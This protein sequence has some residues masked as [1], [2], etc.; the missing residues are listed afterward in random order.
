MNNVNYLKYWT[1]IS[2]YQYASFDIFDTLVK[3]NVPSPADVFRIVENKYNAKYPEN[4]IVE[5]TEKRKQAERMARK[6]KIREEINFEDIYNYIDFTMEIKSKLMRIEIQTEKSVCTPNYPIKKLYRK[7]LENKMK[8]IITSDMYLPETVIIQILQK[9]GYEDYYKLYLSSNIGF[10]KITGNLFRYILKDLKINAKQMIHIGDSK[11]ADFIS[12]FKQGIHPI[13]ISRNIKNTNFVRGEE[14]KKD[15]YIFI[16]NKLPKYENETEMFQWGYEAYGPLI[17][18]FC[19]WIHNI[20]KEK[21]IEQM[22][23]LARDMNLIFEIYSKLYSEDTVKYLEVSRRSLRIAYILKKGHI[24]SVY[25]TMA[26]IKYSVSQICCSIGLEPQEIISC[27]RSYGITLKES[28]EF[29]KNSTEE[30]NI[31]EHII[32]NKLQVFDDKLCD[33]L[34]YM[35]VLDE[36]KTAIID[37]GWHG[38]IQNMLEIITDKKFTGIYLGSTIRNYF[39]KMDIQGFWFEAED[40]FSILPKL[41]MMCILEVMLFPKIGT[42]ISY[43]Q[44]EKAVVPIYGPCEMN[45]SYHFV[46][47]FQNGAVQFVKDYIET[48]SDNNFLISP[49]VSLMAYEKMAFQ[50]TLHQARQLGSLPYEEGK[51]VKLA[52]AGKLYHYIIK[53]KDLIKDYSAAKWKTGFIKQLFPFIQNPHKIDAAIKNRNKKQ[54]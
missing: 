35:G 23:F 44:K 17:L 27:C 46:H 19:V 28:D 8:I 1:T 2:Q 24:D 48:Y 36:Q 20:Y 47:K 43:E 12:S 7:C 33:Y 21:H 9:C 39:R 37:I 4:Q 34:V 51:V 49:D 6:N 42:T 5:F 31:L 41:T 40:E 53:P 22:F 11:K 25:D 15:P 3:R 50:P 38:T 10:Q 26:R 52:D 18:G 45:E 16:N 54:G 29:P 30:Y 32:M 13:L 14:L